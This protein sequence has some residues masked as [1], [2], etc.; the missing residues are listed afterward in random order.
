[1]GV[2][3]DVI[4]TETESSNIGENFNFTDDLIHNLDLNVKSIMVVTKTGVQKRV[5]AAF[6]KQMPN[7]EGIITALNE[8]FERNLLNHYMHDIPLEEVICLLVSDL[9]KLHTYFE[10]GYQTYVEVP[11]EIIEIYNE[12]INNC[13]GKYTQ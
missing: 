3:E 11:V 13:Y 2:P 7:Y 9:Q 5:K 6:E 1:M 8:S 12:L 4:Y 10:K